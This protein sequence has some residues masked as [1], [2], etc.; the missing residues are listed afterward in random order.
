MFSNVIVVSLSVIRSILVVMIKV[1]AF[2]G[3]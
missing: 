2:K 3:A 1:F